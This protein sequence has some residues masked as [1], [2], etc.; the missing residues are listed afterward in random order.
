M[1]D[2]KQ[3][4]QSSVVVEP[5]CQ[6]PSGQSAGPIQAQVSL[7]ILGKYGLNDLT[8]I[9]DYQ[10]LKK[11]KH[12]RIYWAQTANFEDNTKPKIKLRSKL[13]VSAPSPPQL[14]KLIKALRDGGACAHVRKDDQSASTEALSHSQMPVVEKI[15][16]IDH[17]WLTWALHQANQQWAFSLPGNERSC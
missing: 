6:Q 8:S 15:R 4:A 17:G 13:H 2:W 14:C 12:V 1:L 11:Q 9:S 3:G 7:A 16:P 10:F 5:F